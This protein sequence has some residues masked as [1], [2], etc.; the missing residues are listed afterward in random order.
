MLSQFFCFVGGGNSCV[1]LGERGCKRRKIKVELLNGLTRE[2]SKTTA[3]VLPKTIEL[4]LPETIPTAL[5]ETPRN[6]IPGMIAVTIPETWF[7][8]IVPA[9]ISHTVPETLSLF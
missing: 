4:A 2:N 9:T 8:R 7:L 1:Y 5:P 6:M 3:I